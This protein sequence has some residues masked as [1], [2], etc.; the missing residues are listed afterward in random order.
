MIGDG[1][2]EYHFNERI[3]SASMA[4]GY[5]FEIISAKTSENLTI[6]EMK[7]IGVAPIYFDSYVSIDGIKSEENLKN[8]LPGET[9]EFNIQTN[10]TNQK[11]KFE[12]SKLLNNQIIEFQG[13][14][15]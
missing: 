13:N 15:K 1:Q 10:Y 9:K 3:K 4:C 11:I 14:D 8:L 5:K 6:I 12:C 7:N 2:P